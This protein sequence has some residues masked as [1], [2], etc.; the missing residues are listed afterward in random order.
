MLKSSARRAL[1]G[2]L[3]PVFTGS[4]SIANVVAAA[5]WA[6]CGV[7]AWPIFQA[8]HVP[9]IGE[10]VALPVLDQS[11]GAATA[12]DV[13]YPTAQLGMSPRA[14]RQAQQAVD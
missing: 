4:V 8:G 9:M 1:R 10:W 6:K 11:H 5:R 7:A 14:W 12:E 3:R 13:L 2:Q